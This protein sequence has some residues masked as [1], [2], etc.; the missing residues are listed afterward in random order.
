M[1]TTL[2]VKDEQ[3]LKY[4]V[5]TPK[6]LKEYSEL[7]IGVDEGHEKWLFLHTI[8]DKIVKAVQAGTVKVVKDTISA[9]KQTH[10]IRGAN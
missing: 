1:S 4:N 2:N 8:Q 7:S 5:L 6:E 9:P 3:L 10:S